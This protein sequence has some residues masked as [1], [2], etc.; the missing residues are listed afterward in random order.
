MWVHPKAKD[1]RL[2]KTSHNMQPGLYNALE[3]AP[4]EEQN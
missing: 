2:C 3:T 4:S 1:Q